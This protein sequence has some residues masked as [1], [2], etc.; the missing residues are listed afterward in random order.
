MTTRVQAL[1]L[2]DPQNT[3]GVC[4][5]VLL[6]CICNFDCENNINIINK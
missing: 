1:D 2:K 3:F 5:I 4:D 6:N